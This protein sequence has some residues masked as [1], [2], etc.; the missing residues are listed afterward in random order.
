MDTNIA[1]TYIVTY[2]V[3]DAAGNAA[4][5]VSRTVNVIPDTTAPVI[6]LN[7]NATIDLNVG[8]IYTEAGATATDDLDG[9][10]TANIVIAGDVVDTSIAGTYVVTYNV[11]DAAGNAATL[12]SRTVNVNSVP[13][14]V[15]IHQGFFETGL[16]GWIDGGSDC[17]RRSDSRSYE[18][19][20][21]IRIR[22]NSGTASSM[23]YSNVDLTSFAEVQVDFYFY[24]FSFENTED[25]WL[26]FF[27]GSSW[28]TVETWARTIEINNNTF[29]NATVV[30][31]ASVYNFASNSG[32]RFQCD[33]SGNADQIFIDQ[34]TITGF[35]SATG[36]GNSLVNLGGTT[37]TEIN[38]QVEEEEEFIVYPNPVRGNFINVSVP[39]TSNFDYKIMNMIGQIVA[40]GK[41]TGKVNVDRI[42]SGVYMLQVFDGDELLTKRF[43][44][45]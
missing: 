15:V 38:K 20:F 30:I 26:R 6:T 39:G 35:G 4:T 8:D 44:K 7:G 16:D 12:V 24:V 42:E 36:S 29:Y 33:A 22:D 19:N 14:D 34:V 37:K 9:D 27:D 31:P 11:S 41:S 21:S 1:G 43:I 17:A 5:Q 25:F 18:G 40:E 3:S 2:D 32:F 45:E 23:T 13:T 28:I 10:I